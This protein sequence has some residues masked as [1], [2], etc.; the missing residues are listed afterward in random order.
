MKQDIDGAKPKKQPVYATREFMDNKD[1]DGAH[2]KKFKPRNT[3]YEYIDYSD[4]T[5]E[6]FHTK[7]AVDPLNPV[8][9]LKDYAG[10]FCASHRAKLET[11]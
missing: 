10:Y 8:Y 4:L 3:K 11:Q 6:E 2:P 7:R 1:I 9:N 5:K